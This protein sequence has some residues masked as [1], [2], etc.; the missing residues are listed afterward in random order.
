MLVARQ[1]ISH[2]VCFETG[3]LGESEVKRGRK[4]MALKRMDN[5]LIVVAVTATRWPADFIHRHQGP[6]RS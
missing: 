1:L 4:G 5:V 2:K 6:Q 3:K